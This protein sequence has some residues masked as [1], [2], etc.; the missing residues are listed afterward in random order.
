MRK[1]PFPW[2]RWIDDPLHSH[3][4]ENVG[5]EALTINKYV[6]GRFSFLL[7]SRCREILAA[8]EA[9]VVCLSCVQGQGAAEPLAVPSTGRLSDAKLLALVFLAHSCRQRPGMGSFSSAITEEKT[10]HHQGWGQCQSIHFITKH[11]PDV[12]GFPS[13]SDSKES[14]C[15]VGDM[16]SIPGSGKS[17]GEGKPTPVFLPGESHGQRSLVGYSPWDRKESE[18]TDFYINTIYIYIYIYIERERE[19][20]RGLSSVICFTE[21]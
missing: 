10:K 15:N 12:L 2:A 17:P 18:T 5:N 11:H 1:V 9:G 13:G 6:D 20:E 16:G 7:G 3:R 8:V 4:K 19:R 14:A 21:E